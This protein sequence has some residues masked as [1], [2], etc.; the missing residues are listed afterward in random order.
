MVAL[1]KICSK[2]PPVQLTHEPDSTIIKF[3]TELAE[4]PYAFE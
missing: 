3:Y 4:K 2:E 1:K